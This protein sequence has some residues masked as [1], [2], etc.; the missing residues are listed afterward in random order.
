MVKRIVVRISCQGKY[1]LDRVYTFCS[2]KVELLG[3]ADT[4][5]Q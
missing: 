3:A 1:G 4:V 2:R 5:D